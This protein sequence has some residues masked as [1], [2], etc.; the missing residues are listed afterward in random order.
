MS[1]R[2]RVARKLVR[3]PFWQADKPYLHDHTITDARFRKLGY[4]MAFCAGAINAGGFFAV[5]SYTSHVSGT[6]SRVA[7]S[8]AMGDWKMAVS[9]LLGAL[10]FLF[11]AILASFSILWGQ[12]HHFRSCYGLAMWA[13][14]GFLLL[15]SIFGVAL[16]RFGAAMIAPTFMLLC[17]IMGMHNTVMSVLSGGAVRSTHMTGSTTDL[18]VELSRAL[19]YSK[20][21][22]PKLPDVKVNRPKM[23]LLAGT[24]I[25]FVLGG[26]A[27]AYG[28][29]RFGYY[30]TLPVSGMLFILG[31]GSVGY[32]VKIRMKWWLINKIR[33]RER[34]KR[35]T[36][37]EKK[38]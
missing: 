30:F 21:S 13:E 33:E 17:F 24:I 11:G 35:K 8:V 31:V 9:A 18:G 3:H 10:S 27:G 20:S 38:E 2:K 15:F 4:M 6:L 7:D 37:H 29:N 25:N 32:D 26:I 22:N 12:R 14:A 16:T 28:Y 36:A 34:A 5:A 19:Y 23:L 1:H